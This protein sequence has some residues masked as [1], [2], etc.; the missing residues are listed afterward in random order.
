MFR[1]GKLHRSLSKVAK[2]GQTAVYSQRRCIQARSFLPGL[3]S[4][5]AG[6]PSATAQ[7]TGG[8]KQH[9]HPHG[10]SVNSGHEE[11]SAF[12]E[13]VYITQDSNILPQPSITPAGRGKSL[14]ASSRRVPCIW[15]IIS[16]PC[17]NGCSCRML[18]TMSPCVLWICTLLPCPTIRR[19]CERT[20]SPWPPRCWHVASIPPR[21]PS[22]SSPP[23]PSTPS[24]IGSLAP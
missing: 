21:A 2:K 7:V 10:N 19:F 11:V 6:T 24:S 17:A 20:S 18:V 15:V 5:T 12:V 1:F 8:N 14:V 23:L 16:A 13:I 22:L 9:V 4:R 3:A